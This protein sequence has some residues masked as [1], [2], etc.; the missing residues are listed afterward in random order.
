[1]RLAGPGSASGPLFAFGTARRAST[2]LR[3][4]GLRRSGLAAA[5]AA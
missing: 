3:E 2:S 4:V 1:M 5:V